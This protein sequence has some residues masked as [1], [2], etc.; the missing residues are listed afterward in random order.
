M[1]YF[2]EVNLDER[3]HTAS[4]YVNTLM[5]AVLSDFSQCNEIIGANLMLEIP[6]VLVLFMLLL[7][8]LKCPTSIRDARNV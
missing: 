2:V 3:R 4:V 8:F 7:N 6:I 5:E 1:H